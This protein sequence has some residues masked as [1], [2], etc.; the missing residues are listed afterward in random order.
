MMFSI[1]DL[2]RENTL[3]TEEALQAYFS[4]DKTGD[5]S[6][7]DVIRYS[8]LGGGKR[9]RAFLANECARVFGGSLEASM[10][11]ACA[12]EMVHAYSLIHDDLPAMDNDDFRRG[13]PSC[14]KAFGEAN[15]LLAGDTLLTYA[16]EVLADN[17]AIDDSAKMRTVK[18][19]ASCAGSIGMAGGQYVDL[20]GRIDSWEQL[21]ELHRLKTG[22]LI[23]AACLCGYYTAAET[24]DETVVADLTTYAEAIGLA[25]QITDDI[26]DVTATEADLGKPIGSD[27]KNGKKT[28]LAFFTLEAAAKEAQ[29]LTQKAIDA[30]S[31]YPN[32]ENL[33]L[34]ATWL[35]SRRS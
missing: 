33:C 7:I 8:L 2:L 19:L 23:R 15:A 6:L 3:K 34:L 31:D 11:A 29:R 5:L 12:L 27:S 9:I 14:H 28:A 18:T 17:A 4:T 22:A 16:F 30:V 13:K 1:E 24:P 32:S 26:L 25:F 21:T 35:L 20:D 10:P